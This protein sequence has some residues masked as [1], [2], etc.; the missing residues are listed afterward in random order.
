MDINSNPEFEEQKSSAAEPALEKDG[1]RPLRGYALPYYTPNLELTQYTPNSKT[2]YLTNYNEDM[3]KID[4]F[5]TSIGALIEENV[6]DT[7]KMIREVQENVTQVLHRVEDNESDINDLYD[8]KGK[9]TTSLAAFKVEVQEEITE[10]E[11]RSKEALAEAMK[12]TASVIATMQEEI[13]EQYATTTSSFMAFE[14]RMGVAEDEIVILKNKKDEQDEAIAEAKN[15]A[16]EAKT[17]ADDAN[18]KVTAMDT[19]MTSAE[20]DIATNQADIA[21]LQA[22]EIVQNSTLDSLTDTVASLETLGEDVNKLKG[23]SNI[24][25]PRII[26][27]AA[28]TETR[29]LTNA[30]MQRIG[31]GTYNEADNT[32]DLPARIKFTMGSDAVDGTPITIRMI[33]DRIPE[34]TDINI[35]YP[36]INNGID[37]E[38]EINFTAPLGYDVDITLD[39]NV[40]QISH[41]APKLPNN[42]FTVQMSGAPTLGHSVV[43]KAV[44]PQTL[45]KR[46]L[47]N[48]LILA[49]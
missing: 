7:E 47:T 16:D 31:L 15:I 20:D 32:I 9:L 2:S 14:Q 37:I 27:K 13:K 41:I 6:E 4:R 34:I 22:T 29:V 26:Q 25:I 5:S 19:R 12:G 48:E 49:N 36:V 10:S 33:I 23:N 46:N 17:T 38:I 44:T 35:W 24:K 3:R 8:W 45:I 18:T 30:A 21:S 1:L 28:N 11:N 40:E 43:V 39:L 42:R